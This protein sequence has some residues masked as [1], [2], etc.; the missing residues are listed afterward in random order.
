MRVR[1]KGL[2]SNIWVVNKA[3]ERM[4]PL[5]GSVPRDHHPEPEAW[6]K[7]RTHSSELAEQK[8]RKRPKLVRETEGNSQKTRE[9]SASGKVPGR[10]I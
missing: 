3:V 8:A 4:R 7:S 5:T 1:K 10:D 9:A 6:G 2:G